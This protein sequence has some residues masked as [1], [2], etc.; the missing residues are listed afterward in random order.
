MPEQASPS[1]QAAPQAVQAE[2]ETGTQEPEQQRLGPSAPAGW[3]GKA[4]PVLRQGAAEPQTQPPARQPSVMIGSQ[5]R[6]QPPQ[7]FRSVAMS[8]QR[9]EQQAWPRSQQTDPQPTV[10]CG[11]Q[12]VPAQYSVDQSHSSAPQRQRPS[13]HVSLGPHAAPQPPQCA[14]FV[15]TF[16]QVPLQQRSAAVHSRLPHMQRLAAQVSPGSHA[17]SQP[18]QWSRL[19]AV[20]RQVVPQQVSWTAHGGEHSSVTQTPEAQIWPAPQAWPQ[21]PQ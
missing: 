4:R 14:G 1:P 13:R 3:Q 7:L 12:I 11:Q 10:S 6:P 15:W 9:P 16:W 2:S 8:W 21:V 20:L 19:V 5:T 17:W 18:P